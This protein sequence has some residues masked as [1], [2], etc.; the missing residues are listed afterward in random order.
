MDGGPGGSVVTGDLR[1]G[2]YGEA[3]SGP[4]G[5]IWVVLLDT[6]E[7]DEHDCVVR[8]AT[9]T[10]VSSSTCEGVPGLYVI[11]PESVAE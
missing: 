5:S 11:T 10:S 7:P 8:D 9:A 1:I 4:D 2:T 3:A 6:K